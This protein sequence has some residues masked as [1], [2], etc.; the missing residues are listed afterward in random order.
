MPAGV[1]ASS[2][3]RPSLGTTGTPPPCPRPDRLDRRTPESPSQIMTRGTP[4]S[5][6]RRSPGGSSGATGPPADRLGEHPQEERGLRP[7]GAV[8]EGSTSWVARIARSSPHW[9]RTR[10]YEHPIKERSPRVRRRVLVDTVAVR[11]V[12]LTTFVVLQDL[13]LRPPQLRHRYRVLKHRIAGGLIELV[14]LVV[15]SFPQ[16]QGHM[17]QGH[18]IQEVLR[19]RRHGATQR[20]SSPTLASRSWNRAPRETK[21]TS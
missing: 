21:N 5:R 17:P 6:S 3:P 2:T 12:A 7:L 18:P 16:R 20:A 14:L 10:R 19:G 1:T 15:L 9:I 8:R 11:A 4:G 13:H